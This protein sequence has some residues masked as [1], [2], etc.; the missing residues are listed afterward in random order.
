[1]WRLLVS[2]ALRGRNFFGGTGAKLDFVSFHK[3]GDGSAG[4]AGAVV[5]GQNAVMEEL[6]RKFPS[7]SGLPFF[8]DEADPEKSWWKRQ[9]GRQNYAV[10]MQLAQTFKLCTF[11]TEREYLTGFIQ[12]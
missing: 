11:G 1:M 9:G 4:A 2:G 10:Q 7:I 8:N 6:A 3:K 12:I 5:D